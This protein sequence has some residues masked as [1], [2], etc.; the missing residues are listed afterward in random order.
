MQRRPPGALA[1]T[2]TGIASKTSYVSGGNS[3]VYHNSRWILNGSW[4][5]AAWLVNEWAPCTDISADF[6]PI[7]FGEFFTFVSQ[8]FNVGGGFSCSTLRPTQHT[9]A[10][11]Q[12]TKQLFV[13]QENVRKFIHGDTC[14][15]S[16]VLDFPVAV[17]PISGH[18]INALCAP[19]NKSQSIINMYL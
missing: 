17:L 19:L 8:I 12:R 16:T 18:S 3:I 10:N 2:R 13:Q 7:R 4:H 11:F 15:Y 5:Y 9:L 14:L 1:P 6:W